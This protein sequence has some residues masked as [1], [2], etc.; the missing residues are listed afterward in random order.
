MLSV[1]YIT[2]IKMFYYKYYMRGICKF[3]SLC[4]VKRDTKIVMLW[5]IGTAISD[6]SVG[7]FFPKL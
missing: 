2:L 7:I 6:H 4:K 1:E 3:F 5:L